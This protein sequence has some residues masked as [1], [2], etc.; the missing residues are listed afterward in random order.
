MCSFC[1]DSLTLA[2]II[3]IAASA[4]TIPENASSQ[5]NGIK[6]RTGVFPYLLQIHLVYLKIMSKSTGISITRYLFSARY[7]KHDAT[8]AGHAVLQPFAPTEKQ[9]NGC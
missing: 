8:K 2:H 1:S 3:Q 9:L 4:Q 5:F 7:P 6:S